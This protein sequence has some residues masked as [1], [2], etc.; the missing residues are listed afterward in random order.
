MKKKVIFEDLGRIRYKSAWDYQEK[1]FEQV[2]SEKLNKNEKK[3]Q[4]LLFCEHEH[5]YTLGK[6]GDKHNLL[7]T[8]H[9]C[10]SKN[11]DLHAIDRGGDITY[12]GP[13]QLVAYPIIDLEAFGTGV[14]SYISM[15]EDVVI[16]VLKTY[17]I[18]GEKDN[19][20][21]GVWIDAGIPEKARKI[22]AIGVRA[23]RYVTM[24]GLAL[25]INTDL[26][27]F[28]YINPCGFTDRGVTSMQK[29]IGKEVD[30]GEASGRMKIAFSDVFGMEFTS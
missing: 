17:G 12:H 24:H 4:Y 16:E 8:R 9:L 21:M 15:L 13:G 30:F 14:K 20:A 5:V 26:T 19:K 1:L 23:S 7:I 28:S 2:I 29:E 3:D 27:Y 25:N 6:R 11:I 22:C 18:E 10:E